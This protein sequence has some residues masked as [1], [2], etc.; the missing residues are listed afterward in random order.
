MC[1]YEPKAYTQ[2]VE[3]QINNVFPDI[4]KTTTTTTTQFPIVSDTA[5]AHDYEENG[6][7]IDDET[8]LEKEFKDIDDVIE[9]RVEYRKQTEAPSLE[10]LM[11]TST[12]SYLNRAYNGFDRNE[13]VHKRK[14]VQRKKQ[15]K[16]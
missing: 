13:Y 4:S 6:E 16:D 8:E 10:D 3:L 7:G 14:G 12:E 5:K 9:S 11:K 1:A 15:L 2:S